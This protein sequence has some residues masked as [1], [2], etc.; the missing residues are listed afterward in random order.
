MLQRHVLS[1]VISALLICL[2]ASSPGWADE[3]SGAVLV[4]KPD[5]TQVGC[6]D[7]E[8][9]DPRNGG[10]CWSCGSRNRTLLYAIDSDKACESPATTSFI[11]ASQ[12]SD[13]RVT[14]PAGSF[15]DPRNGGECWSCP[16]G[17]S[18]GTV[19][20]VNTDK[21]CSKSVAKVRAKA[22]YD[23]DTGSLLKA[24][25]SGTFPKALTSKC[26]KCASGYSHDAAMSVSDSGVCY[27][28]A[29]TAYTSAAKI[30]SLAGV[31]CPS[32]Q[33]FDPI[34][35]GSCWT[36][37]AGYNRELLQSVDT[38]KACS[39]P[40]AAY[41][42]RASY[43]RPLTVTS[44]G[45]NQFGRGHFFDLTDGG[46]CWSCPSSSPVRTIHAVTG[47]RACASNTCGG[48]NQRPCYVWERFPSC[49]SGLAEDPFTNKCGKPSDVACSVMVNTV[50]EIR[51]IN[52]ELSRKGR[53]A[54]KAAI[55]AIPG[56][57]ELLAFMETQGKQLEKQGDKLMSRVSVTGVSDQ[58]SKALQ[59]NAATIQAMDDVARLITDN[60][61]EI[62]DMMF[63]PAFVC[64]S[65]EKTA[66]KLRNLGL[67]KAFAQVDR[68]IFDYLNPIPMA[69]AAKA[70]GG[71]ATT[72]SEASSPFTLVVWAG[73]DLPIQW[74]TPAVDVNTSI[75]FGFETDFMPGGSGWSWGPA[76]S[77]KRR[78]KDFVLLGGAIGIG[79]GV[80][81]GIG[82]DGVDLSFGPSIAGTIDV[83]MSLGLFCG[84]SVPLIS[85][86]TSTDVDITSD[87]FF[88]KELGN[89]RS[90]VKDF[91]DSLR[92]SVFGVSYSFPIE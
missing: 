49:N 2:T 75:G 68:S 85:Y 15:L 29:Y 41:F 70:R 34:N 63:D 7:G 39:K 78:S 22:S 24:C 65:P 61:R 71:D 82:P 67:L 91:K 6:R 21:A 30:S 69:Y 87:D 44:L 20:G 86:G 19:Y 58:I 43:L 31:I 72:E 50:K 45:C 62:E 73:V 28:A 14:C 90:F 52:I 5:P 36:C 57:T 9:W 11:S 92:D 38:S 53:E 81:T 33:L 47:S 80:D 10:E 79:L 12:K 48:A 1:R 89:P 77:V 42:A 59:S 66:D 27:K 25:K 35:G 51:D 64:G 26:Y 55:E 46:T 37:P 3:Y 32:G 84:V 56:A 17:Y 13:H 8:I 88:K 74:K 18:R 4:G 54:Q 76:I 23:Y 40:V 60:K 16:S 83:C